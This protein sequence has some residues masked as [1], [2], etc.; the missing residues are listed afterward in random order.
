MASCVYSVGMSTL[1]AILPYLIGLSLI[2]VVVT[3]FSG[4]ITMVMGGDFDRR[5]G[6]KLMR[7]RVLTQAITVALFVLYY[8]LT[9]G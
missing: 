8:F 2:A 9:R 5:Y 3:L 7:L 6:N 1:I 4:L